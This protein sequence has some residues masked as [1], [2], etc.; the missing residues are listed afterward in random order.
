VSRGVGR[1]YELCKKVTKLIPSTS[2]A[3]NDYNEGHT[4]HHQ[5][6]NGNGASPNDLRQTNSFYPSFA[7]PANGLVSSAIPGADGL[8]HVSAHGP[9]HPAVTAAKH[10]EED[11]SALYGDLPETKKRKFILVDDT[12]RGTR[13]R[14]RVM[15]EQVKMAEMPDSYRKSN[16]V[17]PR[18][19]F[20]TEMQ[21]SSEAARDKWPDD[22]ESD[23]DPSARTL[24]P[25]PIL[26]GSEAKLPIPKMTRTKRGK[27][28]KLNDLGY[29]MSWSQSRVF[30]GRTL[31]LQRS[32]DAYR[33]K[34]RSSI[35]AE[36]KD[37]T[38]VAPHFETR[39]GKRKWVDRQKRA[40]RDASP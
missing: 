5:A 2:I 20:P 23:A 9:S 16:S 10:E 30:S 18:S 7:A 29:R 35:I 25:V 21:E 28:M 32:L 19:W 26:D 3:G 36:G 38:S 1:D 40:K 15:L 8:A 11:S 39:V 17:F 31:F 12:Q 13:V 6:P 24:V 14:V 33:N 22:A 34:M 4:H 27:E 37:V